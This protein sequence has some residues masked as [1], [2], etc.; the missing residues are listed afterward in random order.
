MNISNN[1]EYMINGI[2]I[3]PLF[4][5]KIDYYFA[6]RSYSNIE[7]LIALYIKLCNELSYYKDSWINVISI[8]HRDVNKDMF[9]NIFEYFLKRRKISYSY[10]DKGMVIEI[11]E[12]R[13]NL[14]NSELILS[15]DITKIVKINGLIPICDL[16]ISN[17]KFEEKEELIFKELKLE[18]ETITESKSAILE[19]SKR[20]LR[21]NT[22]IDRMENFLYQ[23]TLGQVQGPGSIVFFKQVFKYSFKDDM[24]I[25][26]G[27]LYDHNKQDRLYDKTPYL[28]LRFVNTNR[29]L[30]IDSN[31]I[32]TFRLIDEIDYYE[33]INSQGV[34]VLENQNMEMGEE[35]DREIEKKSEQVLKRK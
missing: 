25:K 27:F 34:E 28:V 1:P 10:T 18:E 20:Y 24:G 2:Y 35:N 31:N 15:N 17:Q 9:F 29:Y 12:Y 26:L 19:Y 23:I 30:I 6:D 21:E 8:D 5:Q 4:V 22:F 7:Y 32:K 13:I 33:Y 14:V 11:G 3:D 16:D